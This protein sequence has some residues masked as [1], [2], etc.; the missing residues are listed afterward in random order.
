MWWHH[1]ADSFHVDWGILS[2]KQHSCTQ[3]TLARV[4]FFHIF[5]LAMQD[6]TIDW[7]GMKCTGCRE[8]QH[9]WSAGISSWGKSGGRHVKYGWRL[10]TLR[11]WSGVIWPNESRGALGAPGMD[12]G[13]V[14]AKPP[15]KICP[16]CETDWSRIRACIVQIFSNFGCFC[17]QNL[18]TMSTNCFNF[19]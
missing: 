7:A 1:H 13:P 19:W 4:L 6:V 18:Q 16:H 12:L 9:D 17:S 10:T 15:A 2:G 14:G 5:Q 8:S 11:N 3:G